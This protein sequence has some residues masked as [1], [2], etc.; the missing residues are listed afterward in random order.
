MVLDKEQSDV[1]VKFLHLNGPARSFHWP[2]QDDICWVPMTH[3]LVKVAVPSTKSGRHYH[4]DPKD[5]KK[6]FQYLDFNMTICCDIFT[7]N[8]S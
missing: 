6:P 5:V 7:L 4:L 2:E 8:V 1:S 3:V